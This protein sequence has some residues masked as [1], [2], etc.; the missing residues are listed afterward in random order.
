MYRQLLIRSNSWCLQMVGELHQKQ[1][2]NDPLWDRAGC[3]CCDNPTQPWFYRELNE[4]TTS[5]IEA[6]ICHIN[7][8]SSGSTLIDQLELYVQ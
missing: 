1:Q 4:T 6:R 5:D 7:G 3:R 2:F 8:F